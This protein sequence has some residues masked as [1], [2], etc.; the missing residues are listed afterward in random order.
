MQNEILK[1]LLKKERNL[2]E[3]LALLRYLNKSFGQELKYFLSVKT[4]LQN[5]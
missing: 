4:I 5:G 3:E 1:I 2:A